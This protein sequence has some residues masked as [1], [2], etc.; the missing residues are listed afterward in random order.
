MPHRA[1]VYAPAALAYAPG[2]C[3]AL[4]LL[5]QML[6]TT[7]RRRS[8]HSTSRLR[9][10]Q[11]DNAK[12]HYEALK[13]DPG[14]TPS[15]IKKSFYTLSKHHHPD[16]N[17]SSP[18]ASRRFMRISEAYNVLSIP[19]KRAAYD[20]DTLQLHR[21]GHGHA[22]H[23][24]H[25]GH[26]QGSYSSTNPAGGR[27]ASGLSRRRA[28]FTG[29]PPSFFR[30]GGWGAQ[31]AKRRA[32]HEG[33]T[34]SSSSSSSSSSTSSSSTSSSSTE[35]SSGS[36]GSSSSSAGT[37]TGAGTMGGM[38]PGQNPFRDDEVP[39]FD[40]AGHERTGRENDR[41]RAVRQQQ[42]ENGRSRVAVEPERGVAGMFFVV[43]GVLMA[44]I[45][46]PL[47]ISR[48]W[49]GGGSEKES[50]RKNR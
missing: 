27:P 34:S 2:P 1:T 29:P 47:A 4:P 3:V 35:N 25:H 19:A 38:G 40:R 50:K 41:R 45:L 15:E 24:H 17:R 49:R 10:K 22:H 42:M 39:H 21:H 28:T 16:H 11:I 36:G 7:R 12:N 37:G 44:S 18:H 33:S 6:T 32:A 30:S 20:R 43:G 26:R 48:L 31:G 9:D 5:A 14:A 13:L 23:G 46:V 8:F